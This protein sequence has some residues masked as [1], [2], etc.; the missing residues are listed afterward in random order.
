MSIRNPIMMTVAVLLLTSC[1]PGTAGLGPVDDSPAMVLEDGKADDYLG[2]LSQEYDLVAEVRV[3]LAGDDAA[4]EG[5]ARTLRARELGLA[6]MDLIT[7]AVD[8]K[9]W[10]E[11]TE[12]ERTRDNSILLRQMSDAIDDLREVELG[13]FVFQYLVEVAGPRDLLQR[14]PFESAEDGLFLVVSVGS[15]DDARTYRLAVTV[16]EE[17]P[18]SYPE[19]L[20]MFQ[21][22]LDIAIHIGDDHNTDWKDI[23]QAESVYDEL[24]ELGFASPVDS[25]D[26][27]ALDSGP[28]TRQLDVAGQA[29]DVRVTLFHANMA[30]DEHLDLLVDAY[31][32]SAASADVVV[33]SGHAGRR[34]DYSGVVLHYGPR[35]AIPAAEFRNLELPE[36]YQIFV[37]AGCETYT[38]YS[39]SLFA[40]PGKTSRNADVLTTVNYSTSRTEAMAAITLLRGL[41][42]DAQGTWWP[43]SWGSLLRRIND[44]DAGSRWTAMYGV[45]GLSDNPRMS[46]LGNPGFIGLQCTANSDCPGIDSL[47]NQRSNDALQCGA[48]C[49][50][51]TGC[52]A[53]NRCI[54][55]GSDVS[56]SLRQCLPDNG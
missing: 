31:R 42:D 39:E 33:Y 22:G 50:H 2:P 5:E 12:D 49:T 6:E 4:L 30:D 15:G 25:F 36:K 8:Q 16:S 29:V 53:G 55:V 27:L 17:T 13:V 52:P 54:A 34:L 48:A 9:I 45:H 43:H 23:S 18:D 56:D 47:C 21:D 14:F 3:T 46:P 40:H 28:F 24:E 26:D 1:D 32:R 19:Y 10:A 37:F 35:A 11:W 38:G 41:L 51:D 7:A 44:A 20:Q